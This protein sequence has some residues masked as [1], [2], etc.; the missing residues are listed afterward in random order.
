MR[1]DK[2]LAAHPAWRK[3][4]KFCYFLRAALVMFG[5]ERILSV[6]HLNPYERITLAITMDGKRRRWSKGGDG[7]VERNPRYVEWVPSDGRLVD[8]NPLLRAGLTT[9]SLPVRLTPRNRQE[10]IE[11]S[12]K[13]G[14]FFDAVVIGRGI[15]WGTLAGV[16]EQVAPLLLPST[17][18]FLLGAKSP[19]QEALMR[20]LEQEGWTGGR[21]ASLA[22]YERNGHG[23]G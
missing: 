18:F 4:R 10:F 17:R 11:D 19:A 15:A 7:Y 1:K 22:V 13:R 20:V 21:I 3:W 6:G 16:L 5:I 9:S 8:D 2:E 14:D 23:N 12:L